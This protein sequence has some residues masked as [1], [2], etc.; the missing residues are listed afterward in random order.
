MVFKKRKNEEHKTQVS[1][2]D[3][4]ELHVHFYPKLKGFFAVPNGG[5]RHIATAVKL[6]KEGVK[7]GVPDVMNPHPSYT[8][9][10]SGFAIEFKTGKNKQSKN[11]LYWQEILEN[12]GWYYAV[13]YS[14]SEAVTVTK[15]FYNIPAL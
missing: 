11:Q 7:S 5:H 13:C 10:Y 14:C 6:K 9:A 1:F 12:A 8:G 4:V 2:F 15:E 3:W